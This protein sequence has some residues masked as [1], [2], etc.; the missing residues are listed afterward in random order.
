MGER[1]VRSSDSWPFK[2]A[3]HSDG[4]DS[5]LAPLIAVL[6]GLIEPALEL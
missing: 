5:N 6:D 1:S 2:Q 3:G 4:I